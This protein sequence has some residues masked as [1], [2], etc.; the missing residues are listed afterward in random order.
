MTTLTRENFIDNFNS[1]L[2]TWVDSQLNL[3]PNTIVSGS[4]RVWDG[5]PGSQSRG[6]TYPGHTQAYTKIVSYSNAFKN[7]MASP[8]TGGSTAPS[9][10]TSQ[11][12]KAD[13][14]IDEEVFFDKIDDADAVPQIIQ[15]LKGLMAK[16]AYSHRV[17]VINHGNI[18]TNRPNGVLTTSVLPSSLQNAVNAEIDNKVTQW[19]IQNGSAIDP[20][21][22]QELI[23]L[24][25]DVWALKCRDSGAIQTYRFNFCHNS[26]HSNVTCYN[27]RGRR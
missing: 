7:I 5:T 14:V 20:V 2:Q 23:N 15:I 17:T 9:S 6:T 8:Y 1:Q 21:V 22:Y 10:S 13:A 12:P 25:K 19:G 24:C 16:Y 11:D 3:D 18:S 26:C 27:S 4:A